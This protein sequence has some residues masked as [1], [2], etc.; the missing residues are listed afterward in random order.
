MSRFAVMDV[1][2]NTIRRTEQCVQE[3]LGSINY[4]FK[5]YRKISPPPGHKN[6]PKYTPPPPVFWFYILEGPVR[7]LVTAWGG[8]GPLNPPR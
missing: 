7:S 3:H 5:Q 6:G 8:G 1:L 2:C 4:K